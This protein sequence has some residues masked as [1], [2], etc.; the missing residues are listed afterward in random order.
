MLTKLRRVLSQR[1][2]R[3]VTVYLPPTRTATRAGTPLQPLPCAG[4]D[5][6]QPSFLL[7]LRR[8]HIHKHPQKEDVIELVL[9]PQARQLPDGARGP[10]KGPA[11]LRPSVPCADSPAEP[12]WR[13]DAWRRDDRG[14]Q[15]RPRPL[16]ACLQRQEGECSGRE[17]G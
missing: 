13:R 2:G 8:R 4:G 3:H 10:G 6:T 7:H 9:P 11:S 5:G 15:V 17:G 12:L 14:R 16:V 1:P